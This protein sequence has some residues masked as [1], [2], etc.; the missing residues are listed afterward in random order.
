MATIHH[1]DVRTTWV[2]QP[3]RGFDGLH[4]VTAPGLSPLLG[5]AD[6]AFGGDSAR[7]N[8]E[9]TFTAA[10]SQCHMLMYLFL[11]AA[12]SVEVLSYVDEAHGAMK[13]TGAT[14]G[15]FVEVT[16][17]PKV[18][19]AAPDMVETATQLHDRAHAM[20]F[21]ANSVNFP[22]KHEPVVRVVAAG[23]GRQPRS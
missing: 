10:L 5:S 21:L 4:E 13:L 12:S 14:G 19:V 9:Q 18:G 23:L 6:P 15:H 20:C 22:V 3:G 2:G 7:W 8:P 1:Y 16:L 17:R 11:C